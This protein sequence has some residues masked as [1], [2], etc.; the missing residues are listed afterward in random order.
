[1]PRVR[2]LAYILVCAV[3]LLLSS[4][5]LV[6]AQEGSGTPQALSSSSSS[7]SAA[8]DVPLFRGNP[9]GT[10]EVLGSGPDGQPAILWMK[11]I[12]MTESFGQ[13]TPAV[14]DGLVVAGGANELIA[15][16]A[17]TGAERWRTA[18]PMSGT[19]PL[20]WNG[21]VYLSTW[22]RASRRSMPRPAK[23]SG[24]F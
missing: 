23:K 13:P 18:Q 9:A 6:Y 15:F 16:D 5:P 4:I 11:E 3:S 2:R 14:G 19:S 8:I 24:N 10:G 17:E 1:M 7:A 21:M 20:I 22:A 12:G